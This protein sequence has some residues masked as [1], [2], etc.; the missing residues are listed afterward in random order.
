MSI[1]G[2]LVYDSHWSN[3]KHVNPN[4]PK[5]GTLK[6]TYGKR[7]DNFT[8][9]FWIENRKLTSV[10]YIFQF[11]YETL[12]ASE[13]GDENGIYALLA[14]KFEIS[15][16]YKEITIEIEPE[17]TFANGKPVSSEDVI[18]SVK[19]AL[20]TDKKYLLKWYRTLTFI[21][22]DR[23]ETISSKKLKFYI[24]DKTSE[25]ERIDAI[26]SVLQVKIV[27]KDMFGPSGDEKFSLPIEEMQDLSKYAGSSAYQIHSFSKKGE[28]VEYKLNKNYWGKNLPRNIGKNN[29]ETVRLQF[30][31]DET[32]DQMSFTR[33]DLD[34]RAE[35]NPMRWQQLKSDIADG[36]LKN[37]KAFESEIKK[38]QENTYF[39]FNQRRPLMR[40]QY[41]REALA[42]LYDAPGMTRVLFG[43]KMEEVTSFFQ[44]QFYA[45]Q[46]KPPAVMSTRERAREALRLFALGGWTWDKSKMALTNPEGQVFPTLKVIYNHYGFERILLFYKYDLQRFNIKLDLMNSMVAS[47]YQNMIQEGDYDIAPAKYSNTLSPEGEYLRYMFHSIYGKGPNDSSVPPHYQLGLNDPV[48][49]RLVEQVEKSESYNEKWKNLELLDQEL[50]NKCLM[51]PMGYLKHRWFIVGPNIDVMPAVFAEGWSTNGATFFGW[52]TTTKSKP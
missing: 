52:S 1:A 8:P 26:E 10:P 45:A 3:R 21:D 5:G 23:T 18:Y 14:R 32:M 7:F 34:I 13:P 36:S 25:F 9:Y 22:Q 43:T 47:A 29:F 28:W 50:A 44:G 37:F 6:L 4:A 20:A 39:A 46:K 38:P 49:D 11:I 19:A 24:Q 16:D 51:M 35:G 15:P 12:A 48:I 41:V 17:A 27:P 42:I 31:A 2:K 40:N 33:G 30:I